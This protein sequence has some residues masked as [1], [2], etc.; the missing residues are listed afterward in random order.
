MNEPLVTV[1]GGSLFSCAPSDPWWKMSVRNVAE[2]LSQDLEKRRLCLRYNAS[3][4]TV[5]EETQ[6]KFPWKQ[7][8]NTGTP[9]AK[10]RTKSAAGPDLD[11]MAAADLENYLVL[12]VVAAAEGYV[13]Q[14][15]EVRRNNP[16]DVADLLSETSTA[17]P[18]KFVSNLIKQGASV[19]EDLRKQTESLLKADSL[20]EKATNLFKANTNVVQDF[21]RQNAALHAQTQT[22]IEDIARRI[23]SR[24]YQAV[25]LRMAGASMAA[26]ERE[27]AIKLV[28]AHKQ[29]SI[30]VKALRMTVSIFKQFNRHIVERL[31]S[32]R[33]E[34]RSREKE[35]ILANAI[36][37]YEITNFVVRY[38]EG[39]Q[40]WGIAEIKNLQSDVNRKFDEQAKLEQKLREDAEKQAD[41]TTRIRTLE[42]V[43]SREKH[44]LRVRQEWD[45]FVAEVEGL[46]SIDERLTER[47]A[48]LKVIRDN[49]R[50]QVT[51]VDLL[52]MTAT[53]KD[54]IECLEAAVVDVDGLEI[55]PITEERVERLL[56]LAS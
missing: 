31:S 46:Q 40:V 44:A 10:L 28:D 56:S 21:K 54:A 53:V 45:A 49:A 14:V 7:G 42:Q 18:K 55:A 12:E 27:A 51:F 1:F 52:T 6:L 41:E 16:I 35:L 34:D 32:A 3:V 19:A 24:E 13:D 20:K 8:D 47:I 5:E 9:D 36:L 2:H 33:P 23:E 30:S 22:L 4:A 50:N 29:S 25:E 38:L 15:L 43:T 39:F 37:V 11:N 48:T 26:K 17:N